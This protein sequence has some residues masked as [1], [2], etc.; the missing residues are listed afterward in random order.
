MCFTVVLFIQGIASTFFLFCMK[1]FLILLSLTLYLW[2]DRFSPRVSLPLLKLM[3]QLDSSRASV[4]SPISWAV[5]KW[6]GWGDVRWQM[7]IC[8]CIFGSHRGFGTLCVLYFLPSALTTVFYLPVPI[9]QSNPEK[10]DLTVGQKR[11]RK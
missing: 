6:S 9:V 10:T 4:A 3:G 11:G 8:V 5:G 7:Q 1:Y 2:F